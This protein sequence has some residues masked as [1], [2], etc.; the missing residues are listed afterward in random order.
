MR[1]LDR[2]DARLVAELSNNAR[3]SNKELAARVKLAPSTC[4]ERVRRLAREGVFRGF[5]ADV[6]PRALGITLQALVTVRLR[7]HSRE[8]AAAFRRHLESRPEVVALYHLAGENDYLLQVA[9]PGVDALRNFTLD[10]LT[11]REE[12][13]HVET[14]LVFEHVR[15]WSLPDYRGEP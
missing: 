9:V 4:L 2:I 10:Q 15:R 12:V 13:A 6:D 5:H 3:L 1:A 14:S 7:Q 8:L 11:A